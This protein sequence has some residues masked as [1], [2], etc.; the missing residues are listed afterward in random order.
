M[1]HLYGSIMATTAIVSRVFAA[2]GFVGLTFCSNAFA[3]DLE[4]LVRLLAP[5]YIAMN[6]AELCNAENAKPTPERR[7][8][9]LTVRTFADH[10]K[11]EVTVGLSEKEAD[12]VRITAA[13][14]ARNAV[15]NEMLFLGAQG[16]YV[17]TD[18]LVRWCERS[19]ADVISGIMQSHAKKHEEFDRLTDDAKK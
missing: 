6:F 3:K 14:T 8:T 19:A 7:N 2:L 9:M 10:V 5:A 12:E 17:P 1:A 16:P 11:T 18:T 15:R 13:D 4:M